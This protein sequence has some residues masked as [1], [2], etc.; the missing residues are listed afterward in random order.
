MVL[1]EASN[2]VAPR[3]GRLDAPETAEEIIR[4]IKLKKSHNDGFQRCKTATGRACKCN[5]TLAEGQR[6]SFDPQLLAVAESLLAGR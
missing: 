3:R 4:K 2:R 6:A 1:L 5:L